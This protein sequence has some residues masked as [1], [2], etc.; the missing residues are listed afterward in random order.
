MMAGIKVKDR[1][2][3]V[4]EFPTCVSFVATPAGEHLI[5]SVFEQPNGAGD[6]E[7]VFF[8]PVWIKERP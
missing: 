1:E 5:V 3:I 8:D 4:H 6:A 7:A 2:G